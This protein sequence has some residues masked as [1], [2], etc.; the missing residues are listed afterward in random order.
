MT[1]VS[2]D[3]YQDIQPARAPLGK[4]FFILPYSYMKRFHKFQEDVVFI[5][6]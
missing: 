2:S 1:E 3:D 6:H 5:K 4:H